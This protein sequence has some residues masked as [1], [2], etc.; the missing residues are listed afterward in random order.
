M[1]RAVLAGLSAVVTAIAAVLTNLFTEELDWALGLGLAAAVIACSAIAFGLHREPPQPQPPPDPALTRDIR[2]DRNQGGGNAVVTV[3]VALTPRHHEELA[4]P[5]D[6]HRAAGPDSSRA[7]ATSPGEPSAS[8]ASRVPRWSLEANVDHDEDAYI[9]RERRTQELA[10]LLV[11]GRRP[12]IC[13]HSQGGVGKT[14]TAY[15]AVRQAEQQGRYETIIWVKVR[16][17]LWH[18]GK[19]AAAGRSWLDTARDLASQLGVDLGNNEATW[20]SELREAIHDVG[21][22]GGGVLTVVDNLELDHEMARF[23]DW[24]H[25]LGFASPPHRTLLTSRAVK[26]HPAVQPFRL[27]GLDRPDAVTL[28]RHFISGDDRLGEDPDSVFDPI[29]DR[30]DGNPLLIKVAAR[31]FTSG[32]SMREIAKEFAAPNDITAYL[33]DSALREWERRVGREPVQ[34]LM[35]AFS[36][37]RRGEQLSRDELMQLAELDGQAFAR[38]FDAGRDLGL[39]EGG[40]SSRN[41]RY[42]IHSL[43]H[44]FVSG[45]IPG[46]HDV[47]GP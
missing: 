2:L 37:G 44:E 22:R 23:T 26:D 47:P 7:P 39:I 21:L 4:A 29:L 34:G 19:R 42:A 36:D 31:R 6:P 46:S 32:R 28:F 38:A 10:H 43:L 27:T 41:E 3:D 35:Y 11:T 45:L 8:P 25:I 18:P 5:V 9:G 12:F 33:F 15:E 20:E 40:K 13:M 1:K 30:V 14:T 24:L 17:D 16:G